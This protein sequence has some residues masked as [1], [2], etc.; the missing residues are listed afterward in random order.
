MFT[1]QY[2]ELPRDHYAHPDAPTEWWWHIGT[3]RSGD[4]MFGFEINATRNSNNPDF[5]YWFSQIMVTDVAAKRHYHRTTLQLLQL[6]WAE[7][8]PDKDWYVSLEGDDDTSGAILMNG[9]S[10]DPYLMTAYATF[11][12]EDS[13]QR[14]TIS[15]TFR[16]QGPPMLVWGT[17]RTAKPEDPNGKTDIEKYNYY[18]SYT[19]LKAKGTIAIGSE[20]HSVEGT[21]W[22]DHEYGAFD[23]SEHW[24]LGDAQLSNGVTLSTYTTDPE[25]I[26]VDG[27]PLDSV[28]SMLRPD[29][30][31]AFY[32][33]CTTTPGPPFFT[34]VKGRVYCLSQ[35]VKIPALADSEL[36]FTSLLQDQEFI[37]QTDP[38]YEGVASVTGRLEGE[39]VTGDGW[40]E[41]AIVQ[42]GDAPAA[43]AG[44]DSAAGPQAET[45]QPV[46]AG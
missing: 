4:R 35:R 9:P 17:G 2:I 32:E 29:G 18:Y 27:Q 31:S 1:S 37:T 22:M 3:I 24:T 42:P 12:D 46:A 40:I 14:V 26:P 21:T 10:G 38:I 7:S 11:H 16:Q 25:A 23:K 41:L 28:V 39:A 13:N 33:N 15:L 30:T 8:D 5:P 19:K 44:G 36:V 34:G 45:A 20:V 43:Q 6:D